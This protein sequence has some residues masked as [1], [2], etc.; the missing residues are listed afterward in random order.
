[1]SS[2]KKKKYILGISFNKDNSVISAEIYKPEGHNNLYL[3][4]FEG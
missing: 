4:V 3:F 2:K 1:M